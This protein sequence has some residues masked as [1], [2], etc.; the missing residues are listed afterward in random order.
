VG[1]LKDQAQEE[2]FIEDWFGV[3][4]RKCSLW[5]HRDGKEVRLIDGRVTKS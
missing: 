2:G 3:E 4:Q 1:C 5:G